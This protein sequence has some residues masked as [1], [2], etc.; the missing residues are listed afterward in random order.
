MPK[1]LAIITDGFEEIETVA[2]VDLLRRA[3][4]EVC[5]C[6]AARTLEVTGR[7]GIILRCDAL[8]EGLAEDDT[9]DCLLLPGGPHVKQL[10]ANPRIAT[11]CRRY[12]AADRWLAAIC[13]APLLLHDA[14]LLT[15]RRYTAHA[16]T[17]GELTSILS[18]LRVVVDGKLITSRGAGT[19]IDFGLSLVEHLVGPAKAREIA[20][21]ISA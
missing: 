17:V 18:G 14:G 6:S 10:R 3:G 20:A 13:A 5:L 12:A 21:S 16:S 2:P 15:G 8:L 4:V 9:V 1:V 7:S 19:S 11:L